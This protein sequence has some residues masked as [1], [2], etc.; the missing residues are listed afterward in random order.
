[1]PVIS[2]F[3]GIVIRM[4]F[5]ENGKHNLPHIHISYNEFRSIYDLN[6]NK[7]EGKLP[8]KQTKL[9][10][11]WIIIHQEELKSLWSLMQEGE[12]YFKIEPL[13]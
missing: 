3:Y 11:A 13:K 10:Q 1:M 12:D 7:L 2:Q 8:T 5:D 6:G 4:F 9:V